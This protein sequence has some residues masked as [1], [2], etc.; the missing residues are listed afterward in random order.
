MKPN[1]AITDDNRR[2][3]VAILNA[4][5]ADEYVLYTK[6]RNYHWNVVGPMFND[7]HKFFETQYEALSDVV[8]EVAERVRALGAPAAGTLTEFG[9]HT[10]LKEQ[11]GQHPEATAMIANLLTDHETVIR[12]LRADVD[13][14]LTRHGDSGTSNFLTDL[15]ERHEKMAWMLRAYQEAK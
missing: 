2:S 13:T 12:Q 9:Q 7:L 14:T 6:T 4:L 11:P 10:R 8:D 3:V 15:M 1:I 5:L